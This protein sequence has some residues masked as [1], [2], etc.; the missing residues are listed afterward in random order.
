MTPLTCASGNT[1]SWY[2]ILIVRIQISK[3]N[4]PKEVDW[5]FEK[6]GAA[7]MLVGEGTEEKREQGKLS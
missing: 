7:G 6:D 1:M 2:R 5:A 3:N 4:L